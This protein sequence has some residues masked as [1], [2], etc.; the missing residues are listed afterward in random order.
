[1]KFIKSK[2]IIFQNFSI[3]ANINEKL[4][5]NAIKTITR[6]YRAIFAAPKVEQKFMPPSNFSGGIVPINFK[7]Q[8][9]APS[10]IWN[11]RSW[12]QALHPPPIPPSNSSMGQPSLTPPL[13]SSMGADSRGPEFQKLRIFRDMKLEIFDAEGTENFEK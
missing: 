5:L 13:K 8:G 4:A 3:F 10:R 7:A 1:M 9:I 6:V 11:M 2:S 12:G